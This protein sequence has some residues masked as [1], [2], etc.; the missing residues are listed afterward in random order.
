MSFGIQAKELNDYLS[1]TRPLWSRATNSLSILNCV[2]VE[3]QYG[4]VMLTATNLDITVIRKVEVIDPEPRD[5]GVAMAIPGKDL[6]VALKGVKGLIVCT[7]DLDNLSFRVGVNGIVLDL[8]CRDETEFPPSMG[9]LADGVA[10][11]WDLQV[12]AHELR[13][14]KECAGVD[15]GRLAY[16]G[17]DTKLFEGGATIAATNGHVLGVRRFADPDFTA[18]I[19]AII[20]GSLG[21]YIP[22]KVAAGIDAALVLGAE[23]GSLKWES[24]R[25]DFRLI[26][27]MYPTWEKLIPEKF[28]HGF[29]VDQESFLRTVFRVGQ[30]AQD[31]THAL[32]VHHLAAGNVELCTTTKDVGTCSATVWADDCTEFP[33]FAVSAV[34][35]A[36]I[37]GQCAAGPVRIELNESLQ[38]ISVTSADGWQALIMPIR[39]VV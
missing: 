2:Q 1:L 15:P 12:L 35:L 31:N 24:N 8:D 37:L 7:P 9:I 27:S 34:Y 14:V 19:N 11:A 39:V 30:M 26:Q 20:P 13:R 21:R 29:T 23:R 22:R 32:K 28:E 3:V 38:P 5:E 36:D 6:A 4:Y 25:I 10:S 33:G 17:I 16:T 18:E